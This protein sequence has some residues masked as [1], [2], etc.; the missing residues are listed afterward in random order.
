MTVKRR[1][2]IATRIAKKRS[3]FNTTTIYSYDWWWILLRQLWWDLSP[4]LSYWIVWWCISDRL[5]QLMILLD[6]C[7]E[8]GLHVVHHNYV[9]RSRIDNVDLWFFNI[10]SK[11]FQLVLRNIS[12]YPTLQSISHIILWMVR[13]VS[14]WSSMQSMWPS[15][16]IRISD[17]MSTKDH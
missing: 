2:K 9:Y 5:I 12:N 3:W 10:L 6:T 13:W 14:L 17:P 1:P 4:S 8:T 11:T 7:I 15:R 16:V